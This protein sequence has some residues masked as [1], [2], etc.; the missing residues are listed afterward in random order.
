MLVGHCVRADRRTAVL[1]EG[2][3]AATLGEVKAHTPS[4]ATQA[5][6]ELDEAK[7]P[8]GGLGRS[9]PRREPVVRTYLGYCVGFKFQSVI[10]MVMCHRAEL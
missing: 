7:R 5:D 3:A 9:A 8:A 2:R 6:V 1:P 4:I 10:G